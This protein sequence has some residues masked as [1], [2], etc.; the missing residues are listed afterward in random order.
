MHTTRPPAASKV[1][2]IFNLL[3]RGFAT[4]RA[5]DSL[6]HGLIST[7]YRLQIGDTAGC[8]PALRGMDEFAPLAQTFCHR[9]T[10]R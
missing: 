8:K 3:Y 6:A 5:S 2:Q 7:G 10:V 1:A 9:I 4:R